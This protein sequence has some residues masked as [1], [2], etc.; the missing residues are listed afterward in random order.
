VLSDALKI[1]IREQGYANYYA[2]FAALRD[3]LR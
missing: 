1:A 3:K 2:A